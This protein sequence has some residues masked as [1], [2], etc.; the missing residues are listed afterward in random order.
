M[1]NIFKKVPLTILALLLVNTIANAQSY[2]DFER[3]I[4]KMYVVVAV[5]IAAF[6]GIVLFLIYFERR[7]SNIEKNLDN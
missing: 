6:I 4:G 7:I 3:S 1:L 5:I 2:A